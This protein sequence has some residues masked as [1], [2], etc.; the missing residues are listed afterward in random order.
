MMV[1][2]VACLLV[3]LAS[4]ALSSLALRASTRITPEQRFQAR[5]ASLMADVKRKRRELE[6]Q[7]AENPDTSGNQS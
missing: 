3:S 5:A 6:R 7:A 2:V 4:L 1:L